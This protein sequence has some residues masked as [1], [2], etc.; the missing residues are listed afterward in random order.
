MTPRFK[1]LASTWTDG[2]F[3]LDN[4]GV[5]HELPNCTVR[6]LSDDLS[7]GAFASVDGHH[8]YQRDPSGQW[9]RIAT[10]EYILSVT[11]A[12]GNNVYIGTD[13]ARVLVLND[14]GELEQIDS[15]DSIQGRD[16]W[17]AG[18]AVI[19]GKE[20]GPPL[21]IRSLSGIAG[22]CVFANVHVGGVPRSVDGGATWEPTIDVELDAH[23]VRISPHNN[24]LIVVATA[25][26]LCISWDGGETWSVQSDDLHAPYC[27]AAA[28]TA[29]HI[30]VAAS[31]SHFSREGA[32]YRRSVEQSKDRLE[33]VGGG[34]PNWLAGIADTSCIASSADEMAII[35][36]RGEVFTSSDAGRTW[37]KREETIA[38]V[39]SVLIVR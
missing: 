32:I 6:G 11:Y 38:G 1:I 29:D 8:L 34:L 20:V 9:K 35:S 22:G 12:V 3:V 36:A 7:G 39:S 14:R 15:F 25:L 23:E 33:K 2:L 30:F 26:G 10:S 13:D 18:T 19:D 21:G 31:E 24:S 4:D 37:R 17:L 16:S 27:S 5:A 28:V